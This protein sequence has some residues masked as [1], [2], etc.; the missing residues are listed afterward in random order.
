M[1]P[2][3]LPHGDKDLN[4]LQVAEAGSGVPSGE[5]LS[6][7]WYLDGEEREPSS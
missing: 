6:L 5:E 1:V 4:S 2:L 3:L 7:L